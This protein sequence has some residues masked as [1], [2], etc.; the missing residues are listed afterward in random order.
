MSKVK[1]IGFAN[2]I[3]AIIAIT[4]FITPKLLNPIFIAVL[5]LFVTLRYFF[6]NPKI[7]KQNFS[8]IH[9]FFSTYFVLLIIS[10]F[11]SE[12]F[13]YGIKVVFSYIPFFIIPL[14]SLFISK[15]EVDLGFISKYYI[16]FLCLI[17]LVLFTVAVYRNYEEGYSFNYFLNALLNSESNVEKF[18]YFNYWYFVYDKFVEPIN[19]QP[20]YLG[21]F[22][23]I[24]VILLLFQNTYKKVKYFFPQFIILSLLVLFCGSRWQTLIFTLNYFLYVVCFHKSKYHKK[25]IILVLLGALITLVTLL[26]P[27]TKTRLQEAFSF[28]E[29][30]YEDQF[31]ST[32]I[33]VKKWSS[34]IKCVLRSPFIGYGAGDGKEV[35][36]NQFKRDK[37]YLAYYNK[38][39]SHNQYLDTLLYIGLGGLLTLFMI[40]YYSYKRAR[41][42]MYILMIT[43]TFLVGFITESML[44]RQWGIIS[45]TFF[46]IIFSTFSF[47]TNET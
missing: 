9:V 31:G 42:K 13:S 37:F 3:L 30:F 1:N 20:I 4:L 47:K 46:S 33:R 26:N 27:V 39:N 10:L 2:I 23:N 15:D 29:A 12:N 32:S 18:K 19:I 44:N 35:L 40:F 14:I 17:F 21:L 28:K 22:A 6:F 45:F 38:Y 43:N 36:L 8:K 41:N 11:Y 25:V 7:H 5:F 34:A 24:G 16:Y